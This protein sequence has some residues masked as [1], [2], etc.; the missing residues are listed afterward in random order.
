MLLLR[1]QHVL[2]QEKCH[3]LFHQQYL[4][5]NPNAALCFH[6]K[7]L[8]RQVRVEGTTS[9]VTERTADKYF[10][11]RSRLSQI[12]AWASSQSATLSD[13][14]AL[15]VRFSKYA[16]EFDNRPVPRPPYWSGYSLQP[17]R[18]EFWLS[19]ESRLHERLSYWREADG[20][21]HKWLFP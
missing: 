2:P 17:K 5:E 6:W 4:A 10:E 14:K 1:L 3:K 20:W 13:R 15:E 21:Q 16:K 12:G 8:R 11:S 19:R 9:P 18:V 7:S